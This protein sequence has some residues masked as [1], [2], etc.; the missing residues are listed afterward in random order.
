MGA[1]R[2]NG[3]DDGNATTSKPFGLR[4]LGFTDDV[5]S[6]CICVSKRFLATLESR[7]RPLPYLMQ[8]QFSLAMEMEE[9]S[10]FNKLLDKFGSAQRET[11]GEATRR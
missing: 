5:H 6:V 1:I 9:R 10:G 4:T 7:P 3:D 11:Y 8:A 2:D